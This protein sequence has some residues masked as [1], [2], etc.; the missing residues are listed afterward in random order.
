MDQKV[1]VIAA[2]GGGIPVVMKGK[3]LEG[4]EA[5]VDKD[6]ASACLG[7]SINAEI[8]I[9]IT[10]IDGVYL[11]FKRKNQKLIRKAKLRQI[12]KYY[13]KGHFPEGNMGPK[14]DAAIKFLSKKGQRVII[15]D[16]NNIEKAIKGLA[17]TI[18]VR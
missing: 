18:I 5:I 4:V 10:D 17:G 14:I 12:K 1:I 13:K 2:G 11:N 7:N 15:T 9:M 16:V 3:S 8:L 6:L